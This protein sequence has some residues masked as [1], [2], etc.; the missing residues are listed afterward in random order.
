MPYESWR[1][2]DFV[3]YFDSQS[4]G[5]K[6]FISNEINWNECICFIIWDI[7]TRNVQVWMKLSLKMKHWHTCRQHFLHHKTEMLNLCDRNFILLK[8]GLL[9]HNG[10]SIRLHFQDPKC[11]LE[12]VTIVQNVHSQRYPTKS[13]TRFRCKTSNI[14]SV[15]QNHWIISLFTEWIDTSIIIMMF[16]TERFDR[17]WVMAVVDA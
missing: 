7:Q 10:F 17:I 5:L 16:Q 1:L 2:C 11:G 13:C 3:H 12:C 15:Q 8:S 4:N 14:S 9:P 6:C